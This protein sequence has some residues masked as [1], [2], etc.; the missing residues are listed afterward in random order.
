LLIMLICETDRNED[1]VHRKLKRGLSSVKT[2]CEHW[3]IEIDED[4]TE[5]ICCSHGLR[6]VEA[7]LTLK[8]QNIPFERE[9]ILLQYLFKGLH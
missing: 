9:V 5:A 2:R 3:N 8:G 4:R 6:R 1:Y 7:H